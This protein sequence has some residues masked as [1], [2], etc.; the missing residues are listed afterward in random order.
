MDLPFDTKREEKKLTEVREREEEDVAHILSEK[1][2]MAYADLSLKEIDNEALRVIPKEEA[3]RAEAAAF[4]KTAK[5]LSFAIHNPNNPALATLIA[6]LTK[7]GFSLQKFLVSKKSLE[8]VLERYSDL[9]STTESRAG[10]FTVATETLEKLTK[11]SSTLKTLEQELN[12]ATALKE[13]DR[14]SHIFE[15]ILAGAF[16]LRASD[17]HFEP[18]EKKTLLRLRIDGIL[19]D[20]YFFDPATYHQLNSRIKLLSGV[21]LNINNQAQDGRFSVARAKNEVEMRIS[22]IPG[23]YGESIVM[24]ILDPEATK[25]SYK[26]LGIHPKL[27]ARLETEIRRPNGMLLTTGPTGSGKTTTLYSFL[28]EIHTPEIKIITIEDP[29][30]YHLDGIVQTQVLGEKY[31]FSEGLKSI[32]RQDPDI[33]MV[34]EIR[35]GETADIAIQAAL[36]GHF[37]F[38]TLHTNNAAG[39]FP[40]LVDLG[41]DPKS[42]GSAV[43]V[44][45]AQRLVRKLNPNKKK[46]RSLTDEEKKMIAKVFEP[47]SDKSLIPKKI[48]TVWDPAPASDE[49]T[50]YHGRIGLY[51]AIFMDDELA[52]F[53]RDNPPE[54][55]IAKLTAK[56]GYL[57][58][59]Q[60]GIL[61]ALAGTTSISEVAATID[62]PR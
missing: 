33:I 20:A 4:V 3:Q 43:T 31:T 61:K 44:S 36:T 6:D 14:V 7:R 51:E 10:M 58:M 21:K 48:E 2:G 30:E 19:F 49:E 47:L 26:E 12:A 34:G 46:E 62:L 16:A 50:G 24:R 18:S 59:A 27:L 38:S 53:L 28:R 42:F 17:I 45:M 52:H 54:N 9:S 57:T 11:E 8:K 39:T 22:F 35:D 40:R 55:E 32:V 1:Y 13:L 60:D 37:V 25:V 15:T 29:V 23:N 41:A 56:Q 5:T